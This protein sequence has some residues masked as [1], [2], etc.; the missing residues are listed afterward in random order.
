[1]VELTSG[2]SSSSFHI[3]MKVPEILKKIFSYLDS[4]SLYVA[5]RVCQKWSA[6]VQL[7]HDD[8]W[9]SLTKAV[10]LMPHKIGPK[11]KKKKGW[12]EQAH[13]WNMCKCVDM[14][15]ELVLYDDQELLLRDLEL[16]VK[17]FKKI[18]RK[19]LLKNCEDAEAA[20][21]LAAARILT[22]ID[23]LNL[24]SNTMKFDFSSERNIGHLVKIV[25]NRLVIHD[26]CNK[27]LPN[28]LEH[29]HCRSLVIRWCLH[30]KILSDA[31]IKSLTGVLDNVVEEFIFVGVWRFGRDF[32]YFENYDGRGKCHVI[33]IE[34]EVMHDESEEFSSV[35][36]KEWAISRGWRWRIKNADVNNRT[37][38]ILRK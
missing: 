23:Q 28:I 24:A 16:T 35:K 14:V 7:I 34:R 18:K 37:F 13:S 5:G 2:P 17:N 20:S 27:D 19:L 22:S 30:H 33:Q 6:I 10:N 29:I 4:N 31:D 36:A 15:R 26:G 25:K 38:V 9:R 21:S 32:S 11:Y 12:I 3:L 8:A 1:M